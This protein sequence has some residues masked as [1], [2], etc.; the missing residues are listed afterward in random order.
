[1]AQ[2]TTDA[3]FAAGYDAPWPWTA[4]YDAASAVLYDAG[5]H[6]H[7]TDGDVNGCPANALSDGSNGLSRMW[8]TGG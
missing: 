6:W 8:S 7:A 5:C 1:M 4:T 3:V 2:E